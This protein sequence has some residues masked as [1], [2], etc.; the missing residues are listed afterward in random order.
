VEGKS[1][2]YG[3]QRERLSQHATTSP[4]YSC[5]GRREKFNRV[6]YLQHSNCLYVSLVPNI[7]TF[8]QYLA[9][10]L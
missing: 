6:T 1:D 9:Q 10:L 8:G 3:E 4:P 5:R 7:I 2:E